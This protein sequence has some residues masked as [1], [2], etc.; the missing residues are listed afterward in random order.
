MPSPTTFGTTTSLSFILF[1]STALF[2]TVFFKCIH[3]TFI[4]YYTIT[5][6]HVATTHLFLAEQAWIQPR[7]FSHPL[8]WDKV[9]YPV[10]TNL[11]SGVVI[12]EVYSD[13]PQVSLCGRKHN[14][15]TVGTTQGIYRSLNHPCF[16]TIYSLVCEVVRLFQ[17][18]RL[19]EPTVLKLFDRRFAS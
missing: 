5:I 3:H 19:G 11:I 10:S 13:Y 4:F 9:S 17:K 7:E 15:R 16:W 8:H 1:L 6:H 2:V 14:N 12:C 18:E